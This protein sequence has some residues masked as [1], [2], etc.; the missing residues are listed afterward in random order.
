MLLAPIA[1]LVKLF[2]QSI[3]LVYKE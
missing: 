2:S 3:S 1:I